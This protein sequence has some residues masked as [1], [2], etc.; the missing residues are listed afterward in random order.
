MVNS[1]VAKEVMVHHWDLSVPWMD[2][3]KVYNRVLHEWIGMMLS[4]IKA[5]FL[6]Q[7]ALWNLQEKNSVWG[8]GSLQ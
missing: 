5:P 4:F 8:R 6:V 7:Y 2:Y 1:M 3:Q